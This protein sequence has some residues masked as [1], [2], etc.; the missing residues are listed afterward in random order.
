MVNEKLRMRKQLGLLEGVALILGIIFGSGVFISPKA[1]LEMTG[2]IWGSLTVWV[3]CGVLSTFGALCYAELGTALVQSGGDY[4]YIT[5][6]YGQLP[7]FLYLWDAILIFVPTSNAIMALTFAN[8]VLQ[9]IFSGCFINPVCRK[10][11]A[12]SIICL[13]TFINSYDIKFTTRLQ[14]LFTFT[15]LSAIVMVVGGGVV[16]LAEGNTQNFSHGWTGTTT[17]ISDWSIAFFLGIFSYS[18]WNYLN[19]MVEELVDPYV[20]LSRA[21]YISLPLVTIVY[22]MANISYLAVLGRDM[23][24]TE[25]IAVDFAS[26]IAGWLSW[27]MPTLVA[28][29]TLGG[30]SVNIMTSSR[31]CFAG[32]RNGHL[33]EILAHINIKCMSPVPSLIFLMLLSLLMLIPENLTSLITYCTVTESFFTTLC[34]FAVIW[35]RYKRPNLHRPIKVQLWMPVIFVITTASLLIIPVVSEPIAVISGSLITLLGLPVYYTLVKKTPKRI[36][37]LTPKLTRICQL[38]FLVAAEEEDD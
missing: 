30:L 27:I 1:V 2:S 6:A 33:P 13:F 19:F 20:N 16:W 3:A 8:N 7:A 35:L 28:I 18:G 14:N 4:H 24:S 26:K 9:P 31:M 38:F 22:V 32:A 12:A 37:N 23:L 15:M 17:S 5:E 11:I 34:C 36:A 25:A 21:I 29:A 10:L